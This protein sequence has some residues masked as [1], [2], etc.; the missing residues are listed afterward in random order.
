MK[1]YGVKE[2]ANLSGVSIRT[3]HHYDA[4]G[5]LKPVQRTE[6]GYRS[7]G[8]DE[9]LRLQQILFY[10]ELDFPL[11]KIKALLEAPDFDLVNALEQH[12]SALKLRQKRIAQLLKTL[13]HTVNELKKGGIMSKPETLYEGLPKEFGTTYREE[14]RQSYGEDA[15]ANSESALQNLGKKGVEALK[16]ELD[17][18]IAR[19]NELQKEPIESAQVQ[20]AVRDHYAIIRQLW[21]TNSSDDPQVE[22]YIGLGSLY[23]SDER[24]LT[25]DGKAQ[26]DF[27]S[28]LQQ[29]M[30]HF[31]EQKL[32]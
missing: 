9:L 13:D 8:A 24:Y 28:F 11:K 21:G 3:L 14:V 30:L 18:V 12:K 4:I 2:V 32:K 1:H 15:L 20:D 16:K 25:V 27:A 19:L 26:P 10:K 5:L 22:A 31:A 17:D 29:A 23:V 7:Y 6:A